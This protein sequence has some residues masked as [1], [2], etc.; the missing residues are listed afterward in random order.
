[1]NDGTFNVLFFCVGDSAPSVIAEAVLNR[2]GKGRFRAFS[3]G[4]DPA[5]EVNPLTIEFLRL[6]GLPA[7]GLRNK[8]W[9]EFCTPSAPRIDFAISVCK[10]PPKEILAALPGNPVRAHWNI[11]DP[12]AVEGGDLERRN[13]FR[14]AFREL[15]NRI[16]LFVL[17]RHR[18]PAERVQDAMHT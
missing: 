7:E 5:G 1:M 16:A 11:S 15:E 14:R 13:A 12:F 10:R 6:H 3:A 4:T 18:I 2:V 9:T 8:S 17:L